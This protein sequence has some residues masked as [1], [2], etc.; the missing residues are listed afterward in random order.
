RPISTNSEQRHRSTPE[1]HL[2]NAP[3]GSCKLCTAGEGVRGSY[4]CTME[5]RLDDVALGRPGSR[6][7]P[8]GA[9]EAVVRERRDVDRPRGA[10]EDHLGEEEADRGRVLEAVA[11]EAVGEEE[12][13]EARHGAE[14]RV[15]VW[16][17]LVE[18]CP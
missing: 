18:A 13:G 12:A 3:A 6:G 2:R 1:R 16:R 10:V 14:D 15:G 8:V 4:R 9:D 5:R 11:A 17:D 7:L